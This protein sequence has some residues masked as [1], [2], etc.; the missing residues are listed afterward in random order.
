M[1]VG[2]E[3][4]TSLVWKLALFSLSLYTLLLLL[5]TGRTFPD[6]AAESSALVTNIGLGGRGAGGRKRSN[7]PRHG[8]AASS[9]SLDSEEGE[10]EEDDSSDVESSK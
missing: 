7:R 4:I 1:L 6:F 5:N 8:Q 10:E 9:S 3:R 2:N